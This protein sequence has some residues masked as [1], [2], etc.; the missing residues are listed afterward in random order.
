MIVYI[1]IIDEHARIERTLRFFRL[2]SCNGKAVILFEERNNWSFSLG[3]PN[4]AA[5][6]LRVREN[7][8]GP[9]S[10]VLAGAVLTRAN[11]R[12]AVSNWVLGLEFSSSELSGE[13]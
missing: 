8:R 4:E 11:V 13:V 10:K 1:Y 3:N 12:P 5:A 6:A 2:S 9:G 7:S